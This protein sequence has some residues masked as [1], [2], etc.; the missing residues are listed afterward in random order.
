VEARADDRG[1]P[2]LVFDREEPAVPGLYG[3]DLAALRGLAGKFD[4]DAG[5]L[6]GLIQGLNSDTSASEDI[7]R[8]P[9]ADRFRGEWRDLK[10]TLDRFVQTLQEAAK[11]I[12][13]SADNVEAA[14]R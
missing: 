14:T 6:N 1:R 9:G 5:T 8:G 10:P 2:G 12:R 11:A 7:W 3:A 4:N 13:T